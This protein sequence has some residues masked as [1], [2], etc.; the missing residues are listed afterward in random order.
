MAERMIRPRAARR[1]RS[2]GD[3]QSPEWR[4][5]GP[6]LTAPARL[7][8]LV[9]TALLLSAVM[10]VLYS[11]G[12]THYWAFI[13]EMSLSGSHFAFQ[14]QPQDAV[15]AGAY[16][17]VFFINRLP[18][19]FCYIA[20]GLAA[21]MAV[22]FVADLTFNPS[23]EHSIKFFSKLPA[24]LRGH[25]P[26]SFMASW[27]FSAESERAFRRIGWAVASYLCFGVLLYLL[28]TLLS[29]GEAEADRFGREAA[30]RQLATCR[31][32]TVEYND[33]KAVKGELC[34]RIGN[35]YIL[36]VQEEQQPQQ[37][38]NVLVKESAV[39]QVNLY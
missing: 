39:K 5:A 7:S 36:R 8:K 9:A 21:V 14:V 30:R 34:G 25:R 29:W 13:D 12:R 6:W 19:F 16:V 17:L 31:T 1:L 35:D 15:I 22:V 23:R 37:R 32:A 33:G 24:R 38:R 11:W 4:I 3:E 26:G 28:M 20:L 2:R 27:G 10:G 18:D